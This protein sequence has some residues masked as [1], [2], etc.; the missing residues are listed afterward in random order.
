MM[1]NYRVSQ[2]VELPSSQWIDLNKID[3]EII[4]LHD[5]AWEGLTCVKV[6]YLCDTPE[7]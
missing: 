2:M 4:D 1:K 7:W 5:I 3:T 6:I